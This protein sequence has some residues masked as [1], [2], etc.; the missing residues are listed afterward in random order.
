MTDQS[1]TRLP[2]EI[3]L[4]AKS[5][6]LRITFDDEVSFGLPCEYLRV[7]SKAAE[8]RAMD[9]PVTGKEDVN[10]KRIEPQGRYAIRLV[11]D[12]GH[13]TGIYSWDSLYALGVDQEKNW[14]AYLE[15]LKEIGYERQNPEQGDKR[16]RV[17]YFAWMAHKLRKESEQLVVPAGIPDVD[18]LLTWLGRRR[19]GAEVLFE[20]QRVR[21]TVN[22]QFSEGFTILQDGDEIGIV[23]NSPTAPATPDLI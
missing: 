15:A 17:L 8:V 7:F 6:I 5:R 10:I 18:S 11:F 19:K 9:R 16:I 21:V 22:R 2:T 13:D 12:D 14:T 20:K 3:N 4:H 23:P 1:R